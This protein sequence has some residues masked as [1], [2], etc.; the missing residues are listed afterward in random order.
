MKR[1]LLWIPWLV[2][3]QGAP[4]TAAVDQWPHLRPLPAEYAGCAVVHAHGPQAP[5]C[6]VKAD[7]TLTVWVPGVDPLNPGPLVQFSLN[8][9]VLPP[10]A[11]VEVEGG[12]RYHLPVEPGTLVALRTQ[13]THL[14]AWQLAL[15]AHHLA[16]ALAAAAALDP[17]GASAQLAA[18]LPGLSG[19]DRGEALLMLGKAQRRMGQLE[20]A[21]ASLAAAETTLRAA[22]H[23]SGATNAAEVQA[24]VLTDVLY[25]FS[26]A[27]ARLRPY[28][29]EPTAYPEGAARIPTYRAA[30]AL[31]VG[32]FRGGLRALDEAEPRTVRLGLDAFRN[33]ARLNRAGALMQLGRADEA[34]EVMEGL[35]VAWPAEDVCSRAMVF[36]NLALARSATG[37]AW[38]AVA[39]AA[40][41]AQTLGTACGDPEQAALVGLTRAE[42]ALHYGRAEEAEKALAAVGAPQG[43]RLALWAELLQ[44]QVALARGDGQVALAAFR[45]SAEIC[46]QRGQRSLEHQGRV[47]EARALVELQRPDE[48]LAAFARA[49]AL[50]DQ[51]L[52]DVPVGQDREAFLGD[53]DEGTQHHIALL[54]ARGEVA[55]ALAVSRRARVRAM[56]SLRLADRL[57]G[58]DEAGRQ[59]WRTA[60]S[61][62]RKEKLALEADDWTLSE[63]ARARRLAARPAAEAR[64]RTL[65][66]EAW[67]AVGREPLAPEPPPPGPGEL[68]LHYRQGPTAWWGF[69]WDA[70]GVQVATLEGLPAAPGDDR[71]PAA[72]ADRLLS[73]FAEAIRRAERIRLVVPGRLAAW[74]LHALPFEGAPLAA[75]HL[76]VYALDLPALPT[77]A[78]PREV[79]V[80]DPR[81]DLAGARAS[82]QALAQRSGARLLMGDAAGRGAVLEALGQAGRLYYAGHGDFAGGGWDSHLRLAGNDRLTPG[83]VLVQAHVPAQVVLAGCET[84][85]AA[86]RTVA[87][88]MSLAHAFAVAGAQAVVATSRPIGDADS[89][90][91]VDHLQAALQGA[92]AKED[93]VRALHQAAREEADLDWSAWRAVV[94]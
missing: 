67:A 20:P 58:L 82:G 80:A 79:V 3:C 6:A 23:L 71:A 25:R 22:G 49:D 30:A 39:E 87:P 15:E 26:D 83:D 89:A 38:P 93:L 75:R 9:E 65:L 92:E 41:E 44:G 52:A 72:L 33:S 62:Y 59:R 11:V 17:P 60:I 68:L 4:L 45:R 13:D 54:L 88:G 42:V 7:A 66:D 40:T 94:R 78:D 10:T 1:R 90:R 18:A 29:I 81:G 55:T 35:A 19:G 32:D 57:E 74:D 77:R 8:H 56:A 2:G 12:R 70:Q 28:P 34:V 5:V 84:A 36:N 48:A 69:A 21:L 85:I 31:G 53:Q 51:V 14:E 43:G 50:V 86:D 63:E 91:F 37:R 64:L 73:P 47:G 61:A 76:V 27:E 24:F 46:G 16:P